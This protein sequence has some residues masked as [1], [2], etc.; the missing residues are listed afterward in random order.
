[1]LFRWRFRFGGKHHDYSCGTWPGEKLSVIRQNRRDAEAI[2][3]LG[4][5]PNEEKRAQKLRTAVAQKDEILELAAALV[6]SRT[7]NEAIS[8]WCD[9]K[10][11]LSRKDKGADVRRKFNKD[12]V[13]TL[14]TLPIASLKRGQVM[15]VLHDIAK[16]APVMA[17]RTH[18]QL[19]QFFEYCVGREWLE[20]NPLKGTRR[21]TVGGREVPRQRILCH[22]SDPSKHELQELYAAVE[23]A[24]LPSTAVAAIWIVLGT[25]C[26]IGELV[27]SRW[28]N[29]DLERCEWHIPSELTKN[30]RAHVVYLSAFVVEHFRKLREATGESQWC[31]PGTNDSHLGVKTITKQLGDR[32]RAGAGLSKRASNSAALILSGGHWTPHDLRRTAATLMGQCGVLGEIIERCLNHQEQ[33]KLQKVYQRNVPREKMRDAWNSLG[34]RLE[35][36]LGKP[37]NVV[38]AQFKA[39]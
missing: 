23:K 13:P 10:A 4:K 8:E 32:Q 15:D 21:E 12:V 25:A 36:L 2:L 37:E 30:G 18:A 3:H 6:K 26:R 1:M 9:S 28:E 11:V 38:M 31:F 20:G 19:N 27:Q 33:N 14:G 34:E 16:R 24:R 29:V 7:V 39:A 17:N 5:N 35:L 22:E